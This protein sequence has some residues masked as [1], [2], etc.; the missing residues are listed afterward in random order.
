MQYCQNTETWQGDKVTIH[1]AQ[2]GHTFR[3]CQDSSKEANQ[4]NDFHDLAIVDP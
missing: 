3:P 1:K 4:G 2:I